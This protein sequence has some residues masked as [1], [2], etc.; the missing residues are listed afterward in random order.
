MATTLV[1]VVPRPS[2]MDDATLGAVRPPVR[3]LLEQSPGFRALP[4]EAQREI[5]QTMVRVAAFMANP[6]GL[7]SEEF[8][9]PQLAKELAAP[10]EALAGGVDDAKGK[11]SVESANGFSVPGT[12]GVP[13]RC[14]TRRASVFKPMERI[15]AALGPMKTRPAA[16]HA[17]AKSAFSL[18]N[19]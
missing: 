13:A 15:E 5:A 6:Q 3:A 4:T 19:P 12:V 8:A 7:A 11:A 14:A 10:V 17:A 9:N 16:S 2:S 18:R 1:D